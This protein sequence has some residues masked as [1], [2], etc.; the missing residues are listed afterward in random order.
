MRSIVNSAKVFPAD[1]EK[2]MEF[3]SQFFFSAMGGG[4]EGPEESEVF[5]GEDK[6]EEEGKAEEGGLWES[7]EKI[8]GKVIQ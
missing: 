8:T 7:K 2:D 6:A 1:A 3:L 5:E 4:P